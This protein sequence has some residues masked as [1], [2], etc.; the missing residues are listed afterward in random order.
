MSR[1]KNLK[2]NYREF[3]VHYDCLASEYLVG[4]YFL[5]RLLLLSGSDDELEEPQLTMQIFEPKV[6]WNELLMQFMASKDEKE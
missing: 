3:E 2:W 5:T 1:W 6:F 4:R